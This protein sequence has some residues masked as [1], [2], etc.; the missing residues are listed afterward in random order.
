MKTIILALSCVVFLGTSQSVFAGGKRVKPTAQLQFSV[1]FILQQ[2]LARKN[3]EFRPE[4]A[5][6]KVSME[7]QTDLKYFQETMS[8]QWGLVPQDFSNAYSVAKNEVFIGDNA[9]Y[10]KKH[11]RCIDDSLAHELA[12]YVQSQYQKYDLND[13]SLEFEAID[14]QTWFRETYCQ[15][16]P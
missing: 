14:I 2:V 11:Q 3:K 5:I 13:E 12:H 8:P 6:P 10:Y 15:R 7:S 9:G 1:D 16:D 4:I